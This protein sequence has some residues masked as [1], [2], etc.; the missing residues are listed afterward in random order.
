MEKCEVGITINV[1]FSWQ[2]DKKGQAVIIRK[3]IRRAKQLLI[4]HGIDLDHQ[5]AT[6]SE[7]GSPDIC[8]L[9]YDKINSADFFISDISFVSYDDKL[10]KHFPNSNV[11]FETGYALARLGEK[12][13]ILF[14]NKNTGPDYLLPFDLR[15][16]RY[17][18]FSTYDNDSNIN[19]IASWIVSMI[20]PF[21]EKDSL[22][23][24]LV[25]T[26]KQIEEYKLF[27]SARYDLIKKYTLLHNLIDDF[28]TGFEN[29]ADTTFLQKTATQIENALFDC[30]IIN[31]SFKITFRKNKNATS[32]IGKCEDYLY[33]AT[34]FQSALEDI[35]R[36]K[37]IVNGVYYVDSSIASEYENNYLSLI[38][39]FESLF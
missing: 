39:V 17:H 1:F 29:A 10:K 6:K 30:S 18:A 20:L 5:E 25:L 28:H 22:K 33:R 26:D 36:K 12:R 35:M 2:N 15:N 27:I 14:F 9:I 24:N 11:L 23:A 16:N 34:L 7:V 4:S 32:L 13:T 21:K 31:D 3:G 37:R 8:D 19:K 38:K